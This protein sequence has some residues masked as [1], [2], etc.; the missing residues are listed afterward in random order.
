MPHVRGDFREAFEK[1]VDT[2]AV[3]GDPDRTTFAVAIGR[4]EQLRSL[5]WI[6]G[7]L[8]NCTDQLPGAMAD[9]LRDGGL[10]FEGGSY[11]AAVRC[12]RSTWY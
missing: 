9:E 5:R 1:L 10:G 7:Q 3:W 12:L 8:W 2:K 6:V 11:A 4:I